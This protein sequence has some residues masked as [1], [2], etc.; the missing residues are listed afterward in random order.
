M[1]LQT[2][3]SKQ[4]EALKRLHFLV[5]SI[6]GVTSFE[7]LKCEL[8]VKEAEDTIRNFNS[9]NE[10]DKLTF[11]DKEISNHLGSVSYEIPRIFRILSNLPNTKNIEITFIRQ[12]KENR[13]IKND[14]TSKTGHIKAVFG[15]EQNY[16]YLVQ[17][18]DL[19][20]GALKE[21]SITFL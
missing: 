9:I 11:K 17:Y 6:K 2:Q 5:K 3:I 13:L 14:F 16:F 4:I 19:T 7:L 1:L 8:I 15:N 18:E 21:D 12:H 10:A 20:F